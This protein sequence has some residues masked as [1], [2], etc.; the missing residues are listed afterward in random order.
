MSKRKMNYMA[1]LFITFVN[2][3]YFFT[4]QSETSNV[5]H[6][7]DLGPGF[8]PNILS[9]LLFIFCVIGFVGTFLNKEEKAITMNNKKEMIIMLALTVLMLIG[10]RLLDIFYISS[11]VYLAA[12]FTIFRKHLGWKK[13]LY[14]G[15]ITALVVTALIYI[16][17]SVLLSVSL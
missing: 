2:A 5:K 12:L 13:S 17:F 7:T 6:S 8:F 4:I 9:A 3:I 15:A 16:I 10:W 11:L 1:L 14:Q